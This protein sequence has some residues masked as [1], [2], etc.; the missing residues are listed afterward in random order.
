MKRIEGRKRAQVKG[1]GSCDATRETG[2]NHQVQRGKCKS[3][4]SRLRSVSWRFIESRGH[5]AQP[6]SSVRESSTSS[7][8]SPECESC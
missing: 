2:K 7:S 6:V 3:W 5:S 1:V 8:E 4:T